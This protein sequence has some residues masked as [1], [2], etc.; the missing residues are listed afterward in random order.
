MSELSGNWGEWVTQNLSRGCDPAQMAQDMVKSG[1]FDEST[2]HSVL[3]IHRAKLTSSQVAP[4]AGRPL[5]DL[6]SNQIALSDRKVDLL[7][8]HPSPQIA[9]LGNVLSDEECD[10]LVAYAE[11]RFMPS[12]VVD[13]ETG[14]SVASLERSSQGVMFRRGETELISRIDNRLA[15][16]T[17]WPVEHAEGL[18]LQRYEVGGEYRPHYDWFN[19]KAAGTSKHLVGAGQRLATMILYLTDVEVGGGTVF[20]MIGHE[21]LPKKGNALFFANTDHTGHGDQRTL[22]AGGPVKRGR[23]IIA[24]K[25]FREFAFR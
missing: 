16:L 15:E 7:F 11:Q 20:P 19:P 4:S 18:Q 23:K 24:N 8:F 5:L 14:R 12:T 3:A 9:L 1:M 22:H 17:H 21:F 25:W 2:A 10:G 13:N 6:S